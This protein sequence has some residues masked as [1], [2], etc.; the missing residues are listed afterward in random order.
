LNVFHT[1]LGISPWIDEKDV[2]NCGLCF[3]HTHIDQTSN[4]TG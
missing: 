4:N 1:F 3:C 2:E